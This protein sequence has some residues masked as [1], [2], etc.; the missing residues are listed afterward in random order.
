MHSHKQYK[1]T[2][3]VY[4]FFRAIKSQT[5]LNFL[6]EKVIFQ[7]KTHLFSCKKIFILF[8]NFLD[9]FDKKNPQMGKIFLALSQ[10]SRLNA[11]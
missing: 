3:S 2:S 4:S 8:V 9:I 10:C 7:I 11:Y 1:K 6:Y 5:I